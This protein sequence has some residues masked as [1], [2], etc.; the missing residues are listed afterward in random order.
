VIDG[1]AL[2]TWDRIPPFIFG[3]TAAFGGMGVLPYLRLI[4]ATARH[5]RSARAM[6]NFRLLYVRELREHFAAKGWT[7]NL[8]VDPRYPDEFAPTSGPGVTMIVLAVIDATY[9]SIG[10]LGLSGA[11]PTAVLVV[12]WISLTAIVLFL[13]YYVRAN[14]SRRRRQPEN[15]F[16]YPS[17]ES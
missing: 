10:L 16:G 8:P 17:V 5:L 15:P 11:R 1:S 13:I 6:N 7:P 9:I 12:C 2:T 14:V 4:E 3:L